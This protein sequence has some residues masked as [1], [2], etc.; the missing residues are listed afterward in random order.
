MKIQRTDTTLVKLG[1]SSSS[2]EDASRFL[3][4]WGEYQREEKYKN[5]RW[6]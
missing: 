5:Q 3:L 4:G 6:T 2:N 1:F